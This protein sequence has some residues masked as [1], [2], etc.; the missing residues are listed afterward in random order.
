MI[1]NPYNNG[2]NKFSYTIDELNYIDDCW[3]LID[4]FSTSYLTKSEL[5]EKIIL[6]VSTSYSPEE[7]ERLEIIIEKM[8]W[9][10]I[11]LLRDILYQSYIEQKTFTKETTNI[12]SQFR[13]IYKKNKILAESCVNKILL[14]KDKNI[15]YKYEYPNNFDKI[16]TSIMLNRTVYETI[17]NNMEN[18]DID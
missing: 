11:T 1:I 10:I 9:N 13:K 4:I 16:I 6:F 17:Y 8:Y 5:R 2:Y 15:F 7:F 18:L 12:N 3:N 14:K